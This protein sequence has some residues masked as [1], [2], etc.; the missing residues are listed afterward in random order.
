MAERGL[1]DGPHRIQAEYSRIQPCGRLNTGKVVG[2]F[3]RLQLAY[4][5]VVVAATS[6]AYTRIAYSRVAV[7]LQLRLLL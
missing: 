1:T 4:I 5:A 2:E 3:P 6:F 7:A